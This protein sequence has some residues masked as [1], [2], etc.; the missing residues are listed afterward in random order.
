MKL[1]Q[2]N[3]TQ[4]G[5]TLHG[6]NY[7]NRPYLQTQTLYNP[8]NGSDSGARSTGFSSQTIG[9]PSKPRHRQFLGLQKRMGAIR[10]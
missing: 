2:I 6:S 8:M 4:L 9:V 7:F 3:E 5:T 10:L 1:K